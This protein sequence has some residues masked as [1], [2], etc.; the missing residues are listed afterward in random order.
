MVAKLRTQILQRRT[1]GRITDT[2]TLELFRLDGDLFCIDNNIAHRK[3]AGITLT[4]S[5]VHW[6]HKCWSH[7]HWKNIKLIKKLGFWGDVRGWVD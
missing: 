6:L 4:L 2:H 5:T 7:R 3:L 1:D